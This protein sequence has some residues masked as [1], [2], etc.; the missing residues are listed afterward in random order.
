MLNNQKTLKDTIQNYVG[1]YCASKW[2]ERFVYETDSAICFF[3]S[4]L[5]FVSE[6]SSNVCKMLENNQDITT[7]MNET[8]DLIRRSMNDSN[9]NHWI[10]MVQ[11]EIEN[12]NNLKARR[13]VYFGFKAEC[14]F[15]I[16]TLKDI[17]ISR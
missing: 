15:A 10:Q 9:A 3:G 14:E 1:I 2:M 5:K 8:C 17:L 11:Q 16:A 6:I 13:M 4:E 12:T 7:I